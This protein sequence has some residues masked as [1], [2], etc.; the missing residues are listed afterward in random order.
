MAYSS[1]KTKSQPLKEALSGF[2][3]AYHLEEKYHQTY[4]MA[5]W[6]SIMG[7]TIAKRT[8]NLSMQGKT[9]FITLESSA[10][11]HELSLA[12]TKLIEKL[13]TFTEEPLVDDIVFK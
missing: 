5:H 6:E 1:R 12:K 8:S 11:R 13:N 3:K 9:L 4:L 7:T 10:L 2:L